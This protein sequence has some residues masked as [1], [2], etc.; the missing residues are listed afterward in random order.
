MAVMRA[1]AL[2]ALA[3]CLALCLGCGPARATEVWMSEAEIRNALI[4]HVNKGVYRGG[5]R[6]TDAYAADGSITYHDA[7]NAWTGQWSFHGNAFC[8]LYNDDVDGGCYLVRQLSANCFDFV[9]VPMDW[10]GPGLPPGASSAWLARGGR[11]E[12]PTTCEET[13]VS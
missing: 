6:W 3:V 10:N 4:G 9:T 1:S 11:S 12:E 5:E 7:R 8:T 2:L 13:P